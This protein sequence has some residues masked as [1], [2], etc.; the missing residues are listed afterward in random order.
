MLTRGSRRSALVRGVD[1]ERVPIG[2]GPRLRRGFRSSAA[3]GANGRDD[4][5]P[6]RRRYRRR[7]WLLAHRDSPD[8][9]YVP[10]RGAR[11]RSVSRRLELIRLAV[12]PRLPASSE[13][14]RWQAPRGAGP[15]DHRFG[16]SI[17]AL[18]LR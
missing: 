13:L 15:P 12:G 8:A 17:F 4:V 9:S 6:T 14:R 7:R 2:A 18:L 11:T 10:V 1:A 16:C 3:H 5:R